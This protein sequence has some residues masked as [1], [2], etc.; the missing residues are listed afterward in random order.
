MSLPRKLS[1]N[2]LLL[3]SACPWATTEENLRAI[4]ESP[5]TGAVTTRTAVAAESGFDHLA[6]KH[7][8]TFFDVAS[9]KPHSSGTADGPVPTATWTESSAAAAADKSATAS[10]NTL[11][12]SPLSLAQYLDTLAR[13]SD[14]LPN[15]SKTAIVSV[16]GTPEEVAACYEMITTARGIR[17]PLAM[18][19]NL[20]CPN[21]PSAPP[22]AYDSASLAAYLAILPPSPQ[23]AVG[24]KTPPYTHEGQFQALASAL[25][26]ARDRISF[27]TATNTLGSC[28]VMQG[29]SGEPVLPGSGVGGMAG[30]PLHPLALGNVASLRR[31]LDGVGLEHVD[32][33][34][35]GGVSDAA[36]YKR[37]RAAGA[38]MVAVGTA[39]GRYGV[40]VF[41]GINSGLDGKW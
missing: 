24:V 2:P 20:S 32:I 1:F 16:T 35:V 37:M 3:N 33:I 27:V 26:T 41:D 8:Y 40:G 11:G 30:P 6:D 25:A 39:L 19:I 12:Y 5:S 38:A 9:G 28:L 15:V 10:L 18:E 14:Q 36:G 34:G 4:L 13:L 31:V 23:I 17:F 22:P 7:R 21:I 29:D